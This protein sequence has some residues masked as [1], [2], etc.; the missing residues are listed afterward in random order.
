LRNALKKSRKGP[1]LA[2]SAELIRMAIDNEPTIARSDRF[3]RTVSYQPFAVA[4]SDFAGS[5]LRTKERDASLGAIL[6]FS[7]PGV[8]QPHPAFLPSRSIGHCGLHETWHWLGS[9]Q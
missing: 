1:A 2:T 4:A 3:T 8:S 9:C 7:K 5:D 6:I